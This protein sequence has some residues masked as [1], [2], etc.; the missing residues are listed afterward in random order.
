MPDAS[1]AAAPRTNI[2]ETADRYE[3]AFELP[4]V[5]EADIQVQLHE[6]TL[7]VT[8]SRADARDEAAADDVRWHRVEHRYGELSRA[9]SLPQDAADAGVDAVYKNGVLTVTVPKEPE[10]QPAQITVRAE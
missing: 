9:V 4:G 3:L 7:T 1:S 5:A 6:R 10:E 8:A 2:L